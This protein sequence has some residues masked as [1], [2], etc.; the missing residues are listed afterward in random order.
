MC[1]DDKSFEVTCAPINL[2]IT[3][4]KTCKA[5]NEEGECRVL[6]SLYVD[7]EVTRM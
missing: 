4:M 1:W 3:S 7:S 2:L 5:L 6:K